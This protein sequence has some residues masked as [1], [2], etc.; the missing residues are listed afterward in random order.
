MSIAHEVLY[1]NQ[2]EGFIFALRSLLPITKFLKEN[3]L[4]IPIFITG[5]SEKSSF[6]YENCQDMYQHIIFI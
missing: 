6:F 3:L 1:P 2:Q 4:S 5:L